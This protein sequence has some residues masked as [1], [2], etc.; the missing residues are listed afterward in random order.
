[1]RHRNQFKVNFSSLIANQRSFR[2]LLN[3]FSFCIRQW[4][5]PFVYDRCPVAFA[6]SAS[7]HSHHRHSTIHATLSAFRKCLNVSVLCL[8]LL[9]NEIVC[10]HHFDFTTLG[11][12]LMLT[13]CMTSV[14]KVDAL[15]NSPRTLD[16]DTIVSARSRSIHIWIF[17]YLFF[18]PQVAAY[19]EIKTLSK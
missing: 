3:R 2:P 8:F 18:A 19:R 7:L 5:N 1:V 14:R 10:L 17:I 16:D 15:C 9:L 13:F 11:A 4:F 6:G 12:H